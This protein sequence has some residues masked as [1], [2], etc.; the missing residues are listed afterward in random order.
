MHLYLHTIILT[1][2]CFNTKG[3]SQSKSDILPE[4]N[5]N[6]PFLEHL[7][8]V[9]IDSVR[10]V[11]ECKSLIN[12]SILFVASKHHSN[13]MNSNSTLSHTEKKSG[14][15]NPQD[16]V[17]SFGGKGYSTGENVLFTF[18]N[19]PIKIGKTK[20]TTILNTY[21]KLA[22]SMVEGWVNSPGH[23]KN[24]INCTYDITGVSVSIDNKKQKVYATQKFA[25]KKNTFYFPKYPVLFPYDLYV[26]APLI[27]SFEGISDTLSYHNHLWGLEH[28]N[29][30]TIYKSIDTL[31]DR[32]P[33]MSIDPT[34]TRFKLRIENSDFVKSIIQGKYDGFAIEIVEFKDYL[35]GNPAY[36]TKPSRRNGQCVLNGTPTKPVYRDGLYNG[37]KKRKKIKDFKFIP[38][39]F[40]KQSIPFLHRF[41]RYNIDRYSSQYFEIDL[42]KTPSQKSD[43]WG[44]NL[45]VIKDNKICK[46]YFFHS[47]CGELFEEKFP[48][49]FIPSD[50]FNSNYTFNPI[51]EV[52]TKTIPFTPLETEIKPTIFNEYINTYRNKDYELDSLLVYCYSSVEGDSTKNI[53]LQ[54][55]RAK[56]I[57]AI[58][59]TQNLKGR[60]NLTTASTNWQHFNTYVEESECWNFLNRVDRKTRMQFINNDYK[61]ELKPILDSGRKSFV[62]FVEKI[63]F[64]DEHLLYY[65]QYE[66][67]LLIDS[68]YKYST[69]PKL[70]KPF[71]DKLFK[72]Y[73]YVHK[74]IVNKHFKPNIL[75]KFI[76]PQI[77][78]LPLKTKELRVLYAFEF[79]KAFKL[80]NAMAAQK[81]WTEHIHA[82]HKFETS[83]LYTYQ[84]Y[85]LEVN[86][87]M[88]GEIAYDFNK[89][90]ELI[91]QL[92]TLY[93]SKKEDSSYTRIPFMVANINLYLLNQVFN[94]KPKANRFNALKALNQL[95]NFYETQHIY[96]QEKALSLAKISEYYQLDQ[97]TR[98][99]VKPYINSPEVLAYL[100]IQEYQQYNIE[101]SFYQDLIKSANVFPRNVWCSM[102]INPC[103]I[104]FQVFNNKVIRDLYCEKCE[105]E[106]NAILGNTE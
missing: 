97:H 28:D 91:S 22:K 104:P 37:F 95:Q 9:E 20:K 15:K 93:S 80:N 30:K 8:K 19:R 87:L 34:S 86:K 106:L 68:I 49:Y 98:T 18:Y 75:T 42:G 1:L 17:E 4:N 61:K 16:R 14:Y 85:R 57:K 55:K 45:L 76:L 12:D 103:K 81:V 78:I 51:Y 3:L 32:P 23:F 47:V 36:Y 74:L 25:W 24:I 11:H 41:K 50:T 92:N 60:I 83:S 62:R 7:I 29:N 44:Y 73:K 99:F 84:T 10:H 58:L 40:K 54:E 65:I 53:K 66:N 82:M 21:R 100:L 27:H 35:C 105:K 69:K 90:Q 70:L 13:Y 56:N 31:L 102:F 101:G 79:P 26:P 46:T 89:A 5:I 52:Y 43:I 59:N 38:Y 71:N 2:F 72:L 67:R 64:N 88:N 6:I 94:N 96:T 48:L 33:L 63:P 39:L 77:N